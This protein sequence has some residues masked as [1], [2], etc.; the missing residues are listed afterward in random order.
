MWRKVGKLES[1]SLG[2]LL[3]PPPWW[4]ASFATKTLPGIPDVVVIIENEPHL[5]LSLG[6]GKKEEG[7]R[8][9]GGWLRPT[10]W[11]GDKIEGV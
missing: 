1:S 5:F 9:I 3:R 2:L 7:E 4:E 6:E 10:R 8:E 11:K